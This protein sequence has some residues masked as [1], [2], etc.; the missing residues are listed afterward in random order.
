MRKR[1]ATL[2]VL[3]EV[4]AESLWNAQNSTPEGE[5]LDKL[6][7]LIEEYKEVAAKFRREQSVRLVRY[8]DNELHGEHVWFYVNSH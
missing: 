4:R 5:E 1:S 7:T 3:V 6:V 8:D 2:A